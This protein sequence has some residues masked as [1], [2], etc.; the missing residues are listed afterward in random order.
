MEE[1]S[2]IPE[3]APPTMSD[4]AGHKWFAQG[5]QLRGNKIGVDVFI[6]RSPR[7]AIPNEQQLL[8]QGLGKKILIFLG[9]KGHLQSDILKGYVKVAAIYEVRNSIV[10]YQNQLTL[11]LLWVD[12]EI[13]CQTLWANYKYRLPMIGSQ[14]L[15]PMI[16]SE[17]TAPTLDPALQEGGMA[18]GS[19]LW[20]IGRL[21]LCQ[22]RGWTS[23]DKLRAWRQTGA[24]ALMDGQVNGV[25]ELCLC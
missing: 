5:L 3:N 14:I 16:I 4:P 23:F 19:Q 12:L 13:T 9:I 20:D 25:I 17:G 6:Y 18:I 22:E 15:K 8:H 7:A 10:M 24:H 11:F 2:R 21:F 1:C